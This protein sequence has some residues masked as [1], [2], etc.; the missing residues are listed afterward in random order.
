MESTAEH[1]QTPM[2]NVNIN[3][4]GAPLLPTFHQRALNWSAVRDEIQRFELNIRAVS[5]GQGLIANADGTQDPCV[6]NLLFNVPPVAACGPDR[7]DDAAT[8][9]GRSADLDAIAAY[10]AFG[11]RAPITQLPPSLLV[12]AG[13][14]FFEQANCQ[15]CHGGP[16]WTRSRIDYTPPAN[17]ADV[18]DG[19]LVRFLE[20]VGTFDPAAFNEIKSGSGAAGQAALVMASGTLGINTPSLL[21][22]F[23]GAPYFHSG[24]CPTL[25][26]VLDNVT[27][28]SAGTAGTDVLDTPLER[29]LVELFLGSIDADTPTFP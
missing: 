26:C 14:F 7:A 23:A 11:I 15:S 13:R 18:M 17:P 5:G 3:A 22:V 19:Q 29:K 8:T 21:S 4:N 28:R 25:E 6:F 10:V 12:S 24:S 20:P 27:H 1:P 2:P 9:T 16:N